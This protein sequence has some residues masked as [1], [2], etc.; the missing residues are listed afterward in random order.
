[1]DCVRI[2]PNASSGSVYFRSTIPYPE[3]KGLQALS[4]AGPYPSEPP[5]RPKSGRTPLRQD[6]PTLVRGGRPEAWGHLLEKKEKTYFV[7]SVADRFGLK[8]S[9][10]NLSTGGIRCET[11]R[12]KLRCDLP[13]TFITVEVHII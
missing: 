11:Q 13:A 7:P 1:M 5:L 2:N 10:I 12:I 4:S 3:R 6:C 8:A 9:F